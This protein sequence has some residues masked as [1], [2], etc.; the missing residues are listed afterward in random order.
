MGHG[1]VRARVSV[2]RRTALETERRRTAELDATLSGERAASGRYIEQLEAERLE[3]VQYH[4]DRL[5]GVRGG[6]AGVLHRTAG[7]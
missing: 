2:G 6:G 3:G 5:S 1:A 4:A 7:G